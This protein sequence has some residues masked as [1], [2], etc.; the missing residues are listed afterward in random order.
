[1][2]GMLTDHSSELLQR[3]MRQ[4]HSMQAGTEI[5][6]QVRRTAVDLQRPPVD[7]G[8]H[9]EVLSVVKFIA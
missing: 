1:M 9:R 8:R 4:P 6:P 5:S 3:T 2:F 7:F